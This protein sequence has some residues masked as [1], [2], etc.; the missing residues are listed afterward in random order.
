[1][2]KNLKN[3][4]EYYY[5]SHPTLEDLMGETSFHASLSRYLMQVLEWLYRGQRCAIYENLNFYQTPNPREYPLAPDIALIKGVAARHLRSWK[6]GKTG[7]APQVVFEIA[8]EETWK[9]DV[10][11]KPLKYALMGVEEY[12]FYDPDESATPGWKHSSQRLMGWHYNKASGAI[13]ELTLDVQGRLWSPQLDSFL[14]PD[15][16]YLRLYDRYGQMRLT[17]AEAEAEARRAEARR[18]E[19]L[20]EKLRSLGIDPDH[21]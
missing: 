1:M 3:E 5:D 4:V 18:A 7:P 10:E 17:Q 16:L 13:T 14:V 19:V 6:I 20:A 21:L 15:G 11:E 9:K 8:S 2:G 12:Y